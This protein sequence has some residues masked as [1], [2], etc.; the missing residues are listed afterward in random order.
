MYRK[1]SDRKSYKRDHGMRQAIM[2]GLEIEGLK[3]VLRFTLE[4][5]KMG[6]I[7]NEGID[8]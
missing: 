2:F 5:I 7:R 4:E 6:R 1:L 8:I 3:K